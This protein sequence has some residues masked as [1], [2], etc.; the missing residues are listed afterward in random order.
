M[1]LKKIKNI[2]GSVLAEVLI[3]VVIISISL[4]VIIQSMSLGMRSSKMAADYV[5]ASVLWDNYLRVADRDG[6]DNRTSVKGEGL[7]EG[8]R[9]ETSIADIWSDE[10]SKN[11]EVKLEF[12]KL[13]VKLLWGQESKERKYSAE[14]YLVERID[15]GAK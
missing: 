4:T 10:G 15:N 7:L 11:N 1:K 8:F 2:H 3:S 5:L 12:K 9:L 13:D 6:Y 14:T